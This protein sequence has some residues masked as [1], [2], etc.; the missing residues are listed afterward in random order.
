MTLVLIMHLTKLARLVKELW[1]ETQ[2]L[3]R[4]LPGPAEE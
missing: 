1:H 4:T 2:R 3:R